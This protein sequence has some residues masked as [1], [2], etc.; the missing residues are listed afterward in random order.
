MLRTELWP[1][2]MLNIKQYDEPQTYALHSIS[3]KLIATFKS[4]NKYLQNYKNGREYVFLIFQNCP[5]IW[6]AL[7]LVLDC[8]LINIIPD[9]L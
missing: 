4:V 3:H 8:M 9:F 6:F 7:L 2:Q 5:V 1:Y